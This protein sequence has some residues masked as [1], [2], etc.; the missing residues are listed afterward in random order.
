MKSKSFILEDAQDKIEEYVGLIKRDCMGFI[1]QANG[2]Y[3]YRGLGTASDEFL[4]KSIRLTGR[5]PKDVPSLLHYTINEYFINNFG[6]PFRNAMFCSGSQHL[7][8]FYGNIYGVFPIGNFDFVWSPEVD[9]LYMEWD[10]V[11]HD[12]HDVMVDN[13]MDE[14]AQTYK[15]DNLE[16]A[17]KSN[18]EIMVRTR[19]Y[20]AIKNEIIQDPKYNFTRLLYEK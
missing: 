5:M 9:D 12:E 15:N 18:N 20:Y 11:E 8:D 7:A 2:Q 10:E 3:L 17:I 4:S 16:Q 1:R 19:D 13:L 14:V 6:A